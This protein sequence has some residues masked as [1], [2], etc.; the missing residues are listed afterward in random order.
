MKHMLPGRDD[1][2]DGDR[3][4][5]SAKI[6][7][8]DTAETAENSD[9]ADNADTDIESK[10]SNAVAA[11]VAPKAPE[12]SNAKLNAI[13]AG[14][15]EDETAPFKPWSGPAPHARPTPE[16]GGPPVPTEAESPAPPA[17]RSS[18][19]TPTEAA[20]PAPPPPAA[21]ADDSP[22]NQPLTERTSTF[23]Q[24]SGMPDRLRATGS[25]PRR[26]GVQWTSLIVA[27]IVALVAV[28]SYVATMPT[29]HTATSVVA[30]QGTGNSNVGTD[31][32]V[33]L[34]NEYSV[35]L[36]SRSNNDATVGRFTTNREAIGVEAKVDSGT[37]IIHIEVRAPNSR[38][39]V[40]I[41]NALSDQA[42]HKVLAPGRATAVAIANAAPAEVTIHPNRPVYL[43]GG[44]VLV[45]ALAAAVAYLLR[46]RES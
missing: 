34:A 22:R 18:P 10:S 4:E 5:E 29:T 40:A 28:I 2:A 44:V 15:V 36:S 27:T 38:A 17:D 8:A 25:L 42:A 45:L 46:G 1:A 13:P 26:L 37:A 43:V 6:N 19:P 32:L 31:E 7:N 23:W 35:F 3:P 24:R 9:T 16:Q 41:A 11:R 20:P 14:A 12:K 30:V 21:A 39:A 33:L